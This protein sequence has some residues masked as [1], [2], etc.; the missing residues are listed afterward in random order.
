MLLESLVQECEARFIPVEILTL[1]RF[2]LLN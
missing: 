2:L 1:S